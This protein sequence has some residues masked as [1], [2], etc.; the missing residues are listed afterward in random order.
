MRKES[1]RLRRI[2]QADPLNQQKQE[3]YKDSNRRYTKQ[4]RKEK[5]ITWKKFTTEGNTER[6]GKCFKWVK[7]GTV[8]Q[9]VPTSIKRHDGKYTL[10]IY[11]TIKEITDTL[12]PSYEGEDANI[13]TIDNHYSLARA[14]TLDDIKQSLWRMNPNKAPGYDN[15]TGKI[16]RKSWNHI[17]I[18]LQDII[19]NSLMTGIFPEPWKKAELIIIPKGGDKDLSVTKSYRPISLLPT[20][21]KILEHLICETLQTQISVN[22]SEDQHGYTKNKSTYSAIKAAVDWTR[23]RNEKYVLGI[24]LDI[25]GAFDNLNWD[26]LIRDIIEL[27]ASPQ[28]VSL[29]KSYLKNRTVT[30]RN[31]NISYT[32]KLTRGCPQGS[33]L[34]PTLWKVA[35]NK[36]LTKTRQ[37]WTNRTCYADDT[38]IQVAANTRN[39]LKSRAEEALLDLPTWAQER[40]LEFSAQ[41]S[42]AMVMKGSLAAEFTIA[43]GNSRISTVKTVKYLGINLDPDLKFD[44]HK[45]IIIEN[46][47]E[48]FSRM[49]VASGQSWGYSTETK[50]LLYN[51][52]YIPRVTY[53]ALFWAKAIK[54]KKDISQLQKAQRRAL[55]AT[56]KAYNTTSTDALQVISGLMPLDLTIELEAAKQQARWSNEQLDIQQ[57]RIEKIHTWQTR[58]DTST[59]G[60]ITYIMVS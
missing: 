24:F 13:Q 31:N 36:I 11:D 29:V 16:L 38:L 21:S 12:I 19:N 4:L 37:T 20:M 51:A 2:K 17:N 42:Q 58:W 54:T 46:S 3:S 44:T 48:M 14:Y 55:I 43:F 6:W 8:Q 49:K 57:L 34:G 15:I 52:L 56:T 30:S 18:Y 22:M 25:S 45:N 27:G 26:S 7:K 10:T 35:I 1:K 32:K 39:Q 47:N 59:K 28:I 41:K 9:Q 40:T 53:G 50:L 60:R 23:S 33:K 5:F